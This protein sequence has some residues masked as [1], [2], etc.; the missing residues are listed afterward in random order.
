MDLYLA[1]IFI[2]AG[3]FAVYGG[4][5]VDEI[6]LFQVFD[7]WGQ[8]IHE[9]QGLAPND[10]SGGWNGEIQGDPALPGVYMYHAQVRFIDGAVERFTGDVTVVR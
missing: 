5:D 4:S 8:V 2:A 10:E 3:A 1:G 9:V 7:R 6:L